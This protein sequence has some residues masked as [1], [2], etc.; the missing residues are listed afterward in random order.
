MQAGRC[1]TEVTLLSQ[2]DEVTRQPQIEVH[3]FGRARRPG[4]AAQLQSTPIWPTLPAVAV[5]RALGS[6]KHPSHPPPR[7]LIAG[8]GM[9]ATIASIPP[10]PARGAVAAGW[11]RGIAQ[12]GDVPSRAPLRASTGRR[13]PNVAGSE[14]RR[15]S[16]RPPRLWEWYRQP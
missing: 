9:K 16:R 1:P 7:E 5:A 2:H 8:A 13:V 10:N 6:R 11:R 15:R 14:G 12:A 4:A 3:A